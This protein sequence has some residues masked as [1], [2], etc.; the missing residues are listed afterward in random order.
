MTKSLENHLVIILLSF[1]TL[2][3]FEARVVYN[4]VSVTLICLYRPLY[5]KQNKN[6]NKMLL[7]EVPD[8]LLSLSDRKGG[9]IL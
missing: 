5:S 4:I 6:T 8:F 9:G 7:D 1:S 3:A 2:E